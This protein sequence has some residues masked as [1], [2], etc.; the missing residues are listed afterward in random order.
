SL[1]CSHG[2]VLTRLLVWK[3]RAGRTSPTGS[4]RP[5]RKQT[6]KERNAS[7]FAGAGRAPRSSIRQGVGPLRHR[8]GDRE[9]CRLYGSVPVPFFNTLVFRRLFYAIVLFVRIASV[10]PWSIGI[11]RYFP[12]F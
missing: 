4:R 2:A 5:F 11:G 10:G 8:E 12:E 1:V 3:G 7:A 9:K 6:A